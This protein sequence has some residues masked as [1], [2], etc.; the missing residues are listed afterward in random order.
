MLQVIRFTKENF[1]KLL[2]VRS[3]TVRLGIKSYSLGTAKLECVET[4]RTSIKT[5]EQLRIARFEDL[6][7]EYAIKDGFSSLNELKE[8]LERI[9]DEQIDSRTLL[10]VVDFM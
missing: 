2:D 6:D 1:D 3:S 10:T 4:G 9:Y 5:I 7:D 8:E